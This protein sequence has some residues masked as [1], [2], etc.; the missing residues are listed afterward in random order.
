LDEE[1][2]LGDCKFEVS[3]IS[4]LGSRVVRAKSESA[5]Q[6]TEF[7]YVGANHEIG[8]QIAAGSGGQH[9]RDSAILQELAVAYNRAAND[10]HGAAGVYSGCKS[11]LGDHYGLLRRNLS[12][13]RRE[14]KVQLFEALGQVAD[15]K[16]LQPFAI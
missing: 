8:A 7:P 11:A 14:R 12:G 2:G 1:V 3:G 6:R 16:A 5:K 10:S 13:Y 4:T 9:A 15:A